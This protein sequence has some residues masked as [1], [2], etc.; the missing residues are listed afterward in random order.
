MK[1]DL[2]DIFIPKGTHVRINDKAGILS[3]EH[4]SWDVIYTTAEDKHIGK[5]VIAIFNNIGKI[6]DV[7]N[8]RIELCNELIEDEVLLLL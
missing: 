6:V 7:D 4:L 8:R 5:Y 1:K 2:T 3:T